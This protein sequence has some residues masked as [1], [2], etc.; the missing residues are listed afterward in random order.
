MLKII[1]SKIIFR[2]SSKNVFFVYFEDRKRMT[3][4][5]LISIRDSIFRSLMTFFEKIIQKT[6][7]NT[8]S[9]FMYE[10]FINDW[11]DNELDL[12]WLKKLFHFETKHLSDRRLLIINDHV[13]HVFVEFVKFC[14]K[15]NIVFLCLSSHIT[16]YFQFFDVDCFVSLN[17]IYKKKLNERNK[18]NVVHIISVTVELSSNTFFQ[19]DPIPR[20]KPKTQ[21]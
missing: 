4:V 16:H 2:R 20:T 12:T 13:S 10:I 1:F 11:I 15:M 14:W 18:I 6:W 7:I 19:P 21:P 9:Y 17:R 3:I 5:E 8:W